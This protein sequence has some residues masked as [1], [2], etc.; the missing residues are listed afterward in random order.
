[1]K[2]L[3]FGLRRAAM[4]TLMAILLLVQ[5]A[6]QALNFELGEVEANVNV[7]LSAG[8]AWRMENPDGALIS[9]RSQLG[10]AG[11]EAGDDVLCADNET[12]GDPNS[13]GGGTEDIIGGCVLGAREH[14]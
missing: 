11:L 8:A 14:H 1:M 2:R 9:K 10:Q 6:A 12:G 3:E 4:A 13:A 5:G 7:L